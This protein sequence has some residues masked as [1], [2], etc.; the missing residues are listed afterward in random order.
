MNGDKKSNIDFDDEDEVSGCSSVIIA[1]GAIS[2]REKVYL[3]ATHK[4]MK[5]EACSG[6]LVL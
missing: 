2:L 3:F 5:M 4:T 1:K 6:K